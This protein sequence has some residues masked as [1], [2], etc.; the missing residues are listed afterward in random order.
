MKRL[1]YIAL[2]IP[3]F[4]FC[5]NKKKSDGINWISFTEAVKLNDSGVKKKFLIDVYTDWCGWCKKMD[6]S[7]YENP[8]VIEYINKNFYAVKLDA[9]MSDSIVF[10]NHVFKKTDPSKKSA[11]HELAVALLNG[12]MGYPSTVFLDEKYNMLSPVQGYLSVENIEMYMRYFVEED[13]AQVKWEQFQEKF[14]SKFNQ[15]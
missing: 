13:F 1:L 11:P 9:E 4:S 10:Q 14:V 15:N 7:T 8:K 3:L 5:Q 6:A 12:K 2:F